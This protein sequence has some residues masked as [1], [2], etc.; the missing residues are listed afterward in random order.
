[1]N[2]KFTDEEL[3]DL[4][5]EIPQVEIDD[6]LNAIIAEFSGKKPETAVRELPARREKPRK[7]DPPAALPEPIPEKKP[8]GVG[9]WVRTV[10]KVVATLAASV[11]SVVLTV[12]FLEVLLLGTGVPSK[13]SAEAADRTIM[14]S[15]DMYMTNHVSNALDGVLAIEKIYWLNDHDLIAP[16]PNPNGYGKTTDPASLQWLL[17]EA[18]A[19]LGIDEFVFSTDIKT[20]PGSEINYY[21]DETIFA[22]TWRESIQNCAYTFAEVKIAHPSQFRRFLAGGTYG[23]DKQ[24]V[25][26]QMA[27]DVNAVLASSGDFYKFR[28]LGTIVYDGVVKRINSSQMDTCFID[29]KGDL[30]FVYGGEITKMDAAQKFV[31]ENNIRFS[32]AF[33]PVLVDNGVRCEPYDYCV[34]EIN[35]TYARAGLGQLG[36]LHYLVVTANR[37]Q[38]NNRTATIHDFAQVMLDKKCWKAYALDG[39]QTGVIAMDGKMMNPAQYGSQRLISDIFYFA[40]ALPDGE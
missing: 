2:D 7:V 34:G 29:D 24:F 30:I 12:S 32:I 10:L 8:K 36:E 11:I 20:I 38:V 33:G 18:S 21:L 19:L 5:G 31:D 4:F 13:G 39:G 23:S 15:Y 25:T 28:P 40:T 22:I 37:W 9:Y 35:D 3:S 1:M 17:D 6:E 16:E 26:T 27:S 14:D